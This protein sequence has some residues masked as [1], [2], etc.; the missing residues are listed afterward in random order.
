MPGSNSD[1]GTEQGG[2]RGG[3]RGSTEELR[4]NGSLAGLQAARDAPED[5]Q[6]LAEL[7]ALDAHRKVYQERHPTARLDREDPDVSR[8]IDA[9][10]FFSLR[11]RQAT[12]RNVRSTFERLFRNYFD[13]MLTPL[14]SM[15]MLQGRANAGRT[16]PALLPRGSELLITAPDG[17]AGTFRTLYDL[18]ILPLS[19]RRVRQ[20]LTRADGSYR[21]VLEFTAPSTRLLQVGLLRLN[22]NY[23]DDYPTALRILHQFRVHLDRVQIV[24]DRAVDEETSGD[25]CTVSYGWQRE[26]SDNLD[27]THP[28]EQVR[29][30]FH[31]PEQELYINVDVPQVNKPWL[32]FALCFDL[33]PS[34]PRKPH[35]N[36]DVFQL[37][38]VP[39]V[40]IRRE[41][42]QT[43]ICDGTQDAYAVRHPTPGRTFDLAS[44]RGVY[45]IT[46]Q[47]LEAL[48][49]GN[50]PIAGGRSGGRGGNGS[51][52]GA[53]D[54]SQDVWE[55][56]WRPDER[57]QPQPLLLVRMPGAFV[58]PRKLVVD[59][60]WYQPWFTRHAIGNLHASLQSRHLEAIEWGTLGGLR[61]ERQ[62]MLRDDFAGLLQLLA[63]KM[64]P[65]L[66][67]LEILS[68]CHYLG[69]LSDGPYKHLPGLLLDMR[70]ELLPDSALRGAG[71]KHVYKIKTQ[72]YPAEDEPLMWTFLS[73][74]M[75]ILDA[76]NQ[77]A[78]VE[79]E[80]DTSNAPLARPVLFK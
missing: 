34:W 20:P 17:A 3:G 72:N 80:I 73:Q 16:E 32:R 68:V 38:T 57:G 63:L 22:I 53:A 50:L 70:V 39:V 78:D 10:A 64:R 77:D 30:F 2:A 33:R 44:V 66:G 8:L 7:S 67:R 13:F 24:Y 1:G 27:T 42:S 21:L 74:M 28:V 75:R 5:V 59:A 48:P 47:G 51:A 71:V 69:T 11:T 65:T 23:L 26:T 18:R 54:S 29:R 43:I 4:D 9:L 12:L 15:G 76:W 41:M 14:P 61:P 60:F 62:S 79:L 40:N 46:A 25:P 37:F 36:A 55:V 35:L 56:E 19:L 31:F 52:L 49:A 58:Q 6:F 45:E